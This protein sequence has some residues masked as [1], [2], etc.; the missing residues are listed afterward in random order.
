MPIPDFQSAMLPLLK[1][2]SDEQEHSAKE[3]RK[4][5]AILYELTEEEMKKMLPSGKSPLF[6][7][8]IQWAW[9]YLRKAEVIKTTKRGHAIITD[10]GKSALKEKPERIDMKYLK[11]YE[12]YRKWFDT[13]ANETEKH[14]TTAVANIEVEDKT[15]EEQLEQ[16]FQKIYNAL[17]ADIIEKVSSCSP[18]FFEKLVV[19]L[20]VRMGY[21]GSL[22]DAGE[23]LGK[24]GDEGID[25]VI[26]EDKL[27]L[28]V[29]YLQAKR[30]NN[31][32]VGRPD[33]QKF[34]GALAGKK[35]RKGIF[36]TTSN[37]SKEAEKYIS[38]IKDKIILIDGKKLAEL[39]IDYNVG[40]DTEIN[41]ELKR[42][43]YDFFDEE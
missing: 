5:L 34:V 6:Q 4:E 21:G 23:V 13:F 38:E 26:K 25:G 30:W 14:E 37:Y 41:Y 33:I 35:A 24:S 39:M 7:N 27:G 17:T 20:I 12:A 11:K 1:L 40:V 36:I 9:F 8:R 3:V 22:A 42:I 28:D 15:P 32:T 43:D 10:S 29:I 16:A 18:A 2:F 19:E 31:N